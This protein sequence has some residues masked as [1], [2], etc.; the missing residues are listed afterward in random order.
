MTNQMHRLVAW[1]REAHAMKRASCDTLDHLAERLGRPY[2]ELAARFRQHWQDSLGQ[3]ERIE[4]CLKALG[5]DTSTFKDLRDR[6][7]GITRAYAV[8][9]LPDEL[10]K[11]CLAAYASTHFAIGTYISLGA[12]ARK[13]EVTAIVDMCEENLKQEQAMAGW[14]EQQIPEATLEDLRP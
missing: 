7:L 14:L 11:D 6:F 9:V 12:A 5:S 4:T 1:L 13:L 3:I 2:P 10:V 8:E